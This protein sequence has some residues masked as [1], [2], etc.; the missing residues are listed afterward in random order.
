MVMGVTITNN[1]NLDNRRV[2]GISSSLIGKWRSVIDYR[3]INSVT[4]KEPYL[5]PRTNE[6]FDVL[7]QAKLMTTFDLTWGYWQTPLTE[8]NK[9]KTVFTT[10]LG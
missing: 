9:E 10:K 8:N 6:A 3:R 1:D 2:D 4:V 7:A 5:I